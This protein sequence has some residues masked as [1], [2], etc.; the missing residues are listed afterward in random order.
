LLV[1]FIY[2]KSYKSFLLN[3]FYGYK[4]R[5]QY[6][7]EH[8]KNNK[9]IPGCSVKIYFEY[10]ACISHHSNKH[11]HN[12]KP[13]LSARDWFVPCNEKAAEVKRIMHIASRME[14]QDN[15]GQLNGHERL[16]LIRQIP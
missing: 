16:T 10:C 12:L 11:L 8:D 9:R 6:P 3:F 5:R 13:A 7:A 4:Y 15:T 1:R 14:K 2:C